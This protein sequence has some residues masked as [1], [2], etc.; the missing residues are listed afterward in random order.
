MK[1]QIFKTL[2][3]FFMVVVNAFLAKMFELWMDWLYSRSI[4][5]RI[6]AIS[7]LNQMYETLETAGI[8]LFV[9]LVIVWLAV[10][11]NG[12]EGIVKESRKLKQSKEQ[13]GEKV[14]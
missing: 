9:V 7:P 14:V 1:W 12:V 8:A 5:E 10:A 4:E 6:N 2:L 3:G 13:K 11:C